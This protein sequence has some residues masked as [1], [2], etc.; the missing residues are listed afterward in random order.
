MGA[1]TKA[2]IFLF[3]VIRQLNLKSSFDLILTQV[4]VLSLQLYHTHE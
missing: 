1:R 3:S 4:Q 2:F